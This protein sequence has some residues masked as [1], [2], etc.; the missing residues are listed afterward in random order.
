MLGFNTCHCLDQSSNDHC[1]L[2]VQ[3]SLNA[4][5]S[6]MESSTSQVKKTPLLCLC[7]CV[8]EVLNHVYV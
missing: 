5:V 8:F 6:V 4:L 1:F 7:I 2:N 3:N